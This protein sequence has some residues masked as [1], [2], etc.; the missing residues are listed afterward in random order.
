MPSLSNKFGWRALKKPENYG[1]AEKT[2]G[3]VGTR[4]IIGEIERG[5]FDGK[6]WDRDWAIGT[7][8]GTKEEKNNLNRLFFKKQLIWVVFTE[9]S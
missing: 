9:T 7:K 2:R 6:G 8:R 4:W 5:G 3:I 1:F